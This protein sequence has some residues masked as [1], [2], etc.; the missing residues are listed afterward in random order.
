MR[1]VASLLLV[2]VLLIPHLA[3]ASEGIAS[4]EQLNRPGATIAY[5]KDKFMGYEAVAQGKPDAFVYDQ[6]QMQPSVRNGQKGV[7]VLNEPL[8]F[9]VPIA[10]GIS[11]VSAIDGLA[12]K[13]QRVVCDHFSHYDSNVCDQFAVYNLCLNTSPP[14][15]IPWRPETAMYDFC[16]TAALSCT[17]IARFCTG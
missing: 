1:R 6:V 11:R 3:F 8:D 16:H 17:K 10:V 13:I 15:A 2:L 9:E 12:G 4:T 5:Y 7:R 14:C